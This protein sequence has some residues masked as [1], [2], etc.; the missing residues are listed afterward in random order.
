M[1]GDNVLAQAVGRAA[2]GGRWVPRREHA[3]RGSAEL[4]RFLHPQ[5][6]VLVPRYCRMY[7]S[8]GF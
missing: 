6:P 7:R 5:Y 3:Q 2:V 8:A 4:L 1:C